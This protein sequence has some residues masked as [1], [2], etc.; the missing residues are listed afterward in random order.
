MQPFRATVGSRTVAVRG[1]EPCPSP[2]MRL[3]VP[4]SSLW[5]MGAQPRATPTRPRRH[6]ALR[7]TQAKSPKLLEQP[8]ARR[9]AT[10]SALHATAEP[11]RRLLA[12]EDGDQGQDEHLT[13]P[14]QSRARRRKSPS[15]GQQPRPLSESWRVMAGNADPDFARCRPAPP[16]GADGRHVCT[17]HCALKMCRAG[18]GAAGT[19]CGSSSWR[20]WGPSSSTRTPM[21][22]RRRRMRRIW[23]WARRSSPQS[24]PDPRMPISARSLR[25]P[26]T[27]RPPRT[28]AQ[29]PGWGRRPQATARTRRGED[30]AGRLSR[31]QSRRVSRM[32]TARW[33]AA[34][35]VQ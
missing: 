26:R 21:G 31:L 25:R 29:R 22:R 28:R 10:A 6:R 17:H 7:A 3:L 24:R 9:G 32:V 23:C 1:A 2:P 33:A 35:R 16:R 20:R 5:Q 15:Q 19:C 13:S 11:A 8:S 30:S 12:P 34:V 4:A 14:A 27:R 18:C